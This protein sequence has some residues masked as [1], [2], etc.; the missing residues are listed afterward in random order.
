MLVF[1][2]IGYIILYFGWDDYRYE[3]GI[4][5]KYIVLQAY[6]FS[7][8]TIVS[9]S[10]GFLFSIKVLK[11]KL[12]TEL[13]IRSFH[14]KERLFGFIIIILCFSV[15]LLYLRN[16]SSIA[17]FTALF[18]NVREAHLS[19]S[20][21][22][23]DFDNYH[24]YRW[25]MRDLFTIVTLAFYSNWLLTKRKVDFLIFFVSLLGIL[26]SLVM[27]TEKGPFAWFMVGMFLVYCVV[28]RDS[29]IPIK[30][31]IVLMLFMIGVLLV[32]YMFFMGSKDVTSA[33][34]S[35]F[36][37]VFSGSIT[38]SYFYIEFLP[39]HQDFLMGRSFP[40]PGGIFPYEPYDLTVEIMNYAFP[41]FAEQGIVGSSPTV[42]WGELYANFNIL[43]VAI[44]PF[45]IGIALYAI[46]VFF[47]KFEST[48]FKIGLLGWLLLHYRTL[49]VTGISGFVVDITLFLMI[50]VS[51][52]FISLS[53]N[54]KIKFY[55][56][57]N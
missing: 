2:Y 16:L 40:N 25:I 6:I 49:S 38:P 47:G 30:Q 26:F 10:L 22:G 35:M 17:I 55:T 13:S 12:N 27:A 9:M 48:P 29:K 53:N 50:I 28:R 34:L 14:Q 7:A 39:E 31:F 43:G 21:M 32:F 19:R 42:F 45:F 11:L 44:L 8:W 23:N 20:L 18:D 36:S 54:L 52:I 41:Q 56:K 57:G 1:A 15:L 33:L 5:N 51:V 24:R 37:R 46:S 3:I 4:Q